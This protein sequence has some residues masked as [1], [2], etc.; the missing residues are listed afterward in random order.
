MEDPGLWKKHVSPSRA[1]SADKKKQLAVTATQLLDAD[2][3]TVYIRS[4]RIRENSENDSTLNI[5][6]SLPQDV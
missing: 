1:I 4:S 3:K 5:R 6:Q 2:C